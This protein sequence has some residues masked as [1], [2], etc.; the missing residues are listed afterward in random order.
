[1]TGERFAVQCPKQ[2]YESQVSVQTSDIEEQL[3][4]KRMISRAAEIWKS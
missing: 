1:V 3:V 4:E 2:V